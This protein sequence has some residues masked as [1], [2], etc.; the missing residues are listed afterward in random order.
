MT[1]QI[2]VHLY[3]QKQQEDIQNLRD[4]QNKKLQGIFENNCLM[5]ISSHE[6][7]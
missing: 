1:S 7:K 6:L 5:K 4:P 2:V 3:A